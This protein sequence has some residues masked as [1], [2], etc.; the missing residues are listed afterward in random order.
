[1]ALKLGFVQELPTNGT[2]ID[3]RRHRYGNPS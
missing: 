2:T 1:V 3:G